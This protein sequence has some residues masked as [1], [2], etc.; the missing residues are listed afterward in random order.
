LAVLE[1]LGVTDSK[2]RESLCDELY[3]ET[4]AHF[5]QI[6]VVEIQKQQQRAGTA[7]RGFRAEDLAADVWDALAP[8]EQQSLAEWL[9]AQNPD[10]KVL[11]IP[12]GRA[13][14][15]E[16]NDFL[17]ANTVFFRAADAGKQPVISITLPS[18]SHAEIIFTLA[19]LGLH[20][21]L[22]LPEA[23]SAARRLGQLLDARLQAAVERARHL[24]R[25]RTSDEKKAED[26]TGLLRHWLIHGKPKRK[27]EVPA[28]EPATASEPD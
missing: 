17:D 6:R 4:S 12:E 27:R 19:R 18:R 22:R 26:V 10:G 15:P 11:V 2:E 7:D 28:P 24:V 8:D 3:R 13:S 21:T 16:A 9:A 1:L 25:S 14:L 5:R 20:G 23:E